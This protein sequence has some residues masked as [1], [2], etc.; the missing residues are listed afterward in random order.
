M[1]LWAVDTTP[2]PHYT[3]GKTKHPL[4]RGGCW[5]YT[6]GLDRQR[7]SRP[8]AEIDHRTVQPVASRYTD[9]AILVH[10]RA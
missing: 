8:P 3:P 1:V 6:A 9:Y 5:G 7:K 2:R 10:S 4:Y